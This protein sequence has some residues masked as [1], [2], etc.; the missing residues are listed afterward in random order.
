VE[1]S[2]GVEDVR[3]GFVLSTWRSVTGGEVVELPAL[4]VTVT[5]RS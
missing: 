1:P 4:S 3:L 2:E 5:R